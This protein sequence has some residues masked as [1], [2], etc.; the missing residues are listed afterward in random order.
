MLTQLRIV[1]LALFPPANVSETKTGTFRYAG[2]TG[3]VTMTREDDGRRVATQGKSQLLERLQ[4]T[5]SGQSW[6]QPA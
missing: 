4:L 3:T 5:Q 1:G 6:G 2:A